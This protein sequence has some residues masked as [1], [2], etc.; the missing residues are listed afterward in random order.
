M[1]NAEFQP[2]EFLNLRFCIGEKSPQLRHCALVLRILISARL[3][4]NLQHSNLFC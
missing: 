2:K 1:G 3:L 4:A